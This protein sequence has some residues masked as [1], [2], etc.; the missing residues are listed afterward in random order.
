[1]KSSI[2]PPLP[3]PPP[4]TYL[5]QPAVEGEA[6]LPVPPSFLHLVP[7]ARQQELAGAVEGGW[8]HRVTVDQADQVLPVMLPGRNNGNTNVMDI[9]SGNDR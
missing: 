9:S 4:Q 7:L 2:R 1:M 8:V 5:E 6:V 3:L